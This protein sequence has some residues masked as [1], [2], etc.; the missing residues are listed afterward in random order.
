MINQMF[1]ATSIPVLEQV[2]YFTHARHDI[3]AGNIA[4]L[5]TPG[6]R[7]RDLSVESFQTRLKSALEN[8]ERPM[9]VAVAGI[10]SGDTRSPLEQVREESKNI[11]FH[12]DT[13]M[14]VEKQL[15]EVAKNQMLYQTALTIMND[16]FRLM[17]AAISEQ[18]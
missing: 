9:N 1:N 17:H 5:D 14:S 6:Y 11:L 18:P 12:D 8:R 10:A 2:A 15:S 7:T 13:D 3:L 16:Q 4:N